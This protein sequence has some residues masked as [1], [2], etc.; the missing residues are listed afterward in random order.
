MTLKSLLMDEPISALDPISTN[1]I[2]DLI[3]ELR[4]LC[5]RLSHPQHATG[6]LYFD[7]TAFFPIRE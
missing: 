6:S 2:E 5:Y 7:K 1:K 4:P 3:Q